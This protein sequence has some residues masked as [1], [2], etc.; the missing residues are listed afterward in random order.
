MLLVQMRSVEE[1]L[2]NTEDGQV[3]AE[4]A[5]VYAFFCF[6]TNDEKRI[7][8]IEKDNRSFIRGLLNSTT[9]KPLG[10]DVPEKIYSRAISNDAFL[11]LFTS[12]LDGTKGADND[13]TSQNPF[14]GQSNEE[15]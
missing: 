1:K 5:Q 3:V 9:V 8:A 14:F 13:T 2:I 10:I 11:G 7:E 15:D 6:D 4:V 12:R